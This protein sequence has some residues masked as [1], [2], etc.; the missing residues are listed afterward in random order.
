LEKKKEEDDMGNLLKCIFG[1]L[2]ITVL[3]GCE[4]SETASRKSDNADQAN[5]TTASIDAC[6]AND[7]CQTGQYCARPTGNCNAEGQCKPM[8]EICLDQ[9]KPICGCDSQTYSNAC[10]AASQGVSVF[11]D[12]DCET[13]PDMTEVRSNLE[14]NTSPEVSEADV[15]S[16]V[17][18]NTEFAMALYQQLIPGSDDNLFFSPYSISTALAMLYGGAANETERQMAACLRFNIPETP[19]HTGFNYLALELQRRGEEAAGADGGVFRLNMANALWWQQVYPVLSSYLDLLAVN[20]GAGVKLLNFMMYPEPSRLAI[21]QWVA[22]QTE[23]RIQ[24]LL[25]EDMITSDTRMVLTNTIYFNAAWARPFKESLTSDAPFYLLGGSSVT[26]SMMRQTEFFGYAEGADFKAVKIPYDG[27]ELTMLI[28]V[29]DAGVFTAFEAALDDDFITMLSDNFHTERVALS[30]P[31]WGYNSRFGLKPVLSDMGMVD[32]FLSGI[33]DFSNMTG[34]TNLFITNVV[35]EA[36]INVDEKGT[37]AAAATGITG[38]GSSMP[39]EPISLTINRPFIYM[40]QD[41]PTGT[42]LFV[43]RVLNPMT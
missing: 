38:D 14:R 21:N 20:Y 11:Y 39:A 5:P 12:G 22:G 2:L 7:Q 17:S 43:G 6:L 36:F 1:L 18:G 9:W 30:L 8:S 16:L 26:A 23:D 25:S 28:I 10:Y 13:A 4:I 34:N 3:G 19:L 37:E 24:E 33:A 32:A 40:I 41:I 35:H 29:P 27:Y 15:V 31:K 42:V